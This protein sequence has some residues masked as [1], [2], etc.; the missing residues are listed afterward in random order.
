MTYDN[1][2]KTYDI[3]LCVHQC[4]IWDK[5]YKNG[6]IGPFLNTLS[7]IYLTL[8]HHYYNEYFFIQWLLW[9]LWNTAKQKYRGEINF[10]EQKGVL[11][12]KY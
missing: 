12:G 1:N 11:Y 3:E 4:N 9:W 7:H 6:P 8:T 2:I 10:L 5:V